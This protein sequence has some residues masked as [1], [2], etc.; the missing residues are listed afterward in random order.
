MNLESFS[1]RKRGKEGRREGERERERV[2]RAVV[3]L[4]YLADSFKYDLIV[5][6]FC[7]ASSCTKSREMPGR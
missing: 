2:F 5:I 4:F 1:G 3:S 6:G 7:V